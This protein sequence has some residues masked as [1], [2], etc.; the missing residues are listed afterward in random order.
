MGVWVWQLWATHMVSRIENIGGNCEKC[1]WNEKRKIDSISLKSKTN[2]NYILSEFQVHYF[3]NWPSHI[4]GGYSQ[5][6]NW[7]NK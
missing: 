3:K 1:I 5:N 7:A 4:T 2:L 6:Y